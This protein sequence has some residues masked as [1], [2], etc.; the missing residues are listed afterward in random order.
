MHFVPL[1]N[2]N[3]YAHALYI[4]KVSKEVKKLYT[5]YTKR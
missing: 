4:E 1:C 5:K 3:G 2:T